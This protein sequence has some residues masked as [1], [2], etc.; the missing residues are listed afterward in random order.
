MR[1]CRPRAYIYIRNDVPLNV[2]S[3]G[4]WR[5]EAAAVPA[6]SAAPLGEMP[7][8]AAERPLAFRALMT[9]TLI[10]L[11]APQSFI[12]AL[13]PLRIALLCATIATLA[14]LFGSLSAGRPVLR[15]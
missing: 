6:T 13:A 14:H 11:V 15:M 12:P 9:F 4:W 8:P 5:P 7:A 2:P 10:L 3:S 1:R